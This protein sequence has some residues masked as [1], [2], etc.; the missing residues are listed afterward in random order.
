MGTVMDEKEMRALTGQ[1]AKQVLTRTPILA[2][3]INYL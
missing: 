1:L 2:N 3:P